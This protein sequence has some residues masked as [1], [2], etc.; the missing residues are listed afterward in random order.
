M[1]ESLTDEG[2]YANACPFCGSEK[3]RLNWGGF[4]T[5]AYVECQTCGAQGPPN[6][7]DSGAVRVWNMRV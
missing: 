3:A 5:Y 7:T 6:G 1:S 2:D 4:N